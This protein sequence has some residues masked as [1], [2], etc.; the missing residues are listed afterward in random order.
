MPLVAGK[1]RAAIGANIGIEENAGKDRAQAAAIAFSEARKAG[2][3]DPGYGKK[4]KKRK[5]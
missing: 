4:K 3:K 1:S 2:M 5:P